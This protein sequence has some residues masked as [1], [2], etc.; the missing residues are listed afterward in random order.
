MTHILVTAIKSMGRFCGSLLPSE[1]TDSA[2]GTVR[3]LQTSCFYGIECEWTHH[4]GNLGDQHLNC[5]HHTRTV[6]HPRS[7]LYQKP[8]EKAA[9]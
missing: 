9:S 8:L 6:H 7:W 5:R 2:I 3:Y 4:Q 1:G